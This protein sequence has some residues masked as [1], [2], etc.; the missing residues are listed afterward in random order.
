MI[1]IKMSR[2]HGKS[3]LRVKGDQ[4]VVYGLVDSDTWARLQAGV[5][6]RLFA[7]PHSGLAGFGGLL[8]GFRGRG[9]LVSS[10]GLGAGGEG[11]HLADDGLGFRVGQ[12]ERQL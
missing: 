3:H 11:D 10:G 2:P 12:S 1:S 8:A 6:Y 9:V 7:L 4:I 5:A